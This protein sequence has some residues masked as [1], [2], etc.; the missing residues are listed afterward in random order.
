MPTRSTT[1]FLGPFLLTFGLAHTAWGQT[2]AFTYQ[3]RLTDNGAAVNGL[4][5]FRAT[6]YGEATGSGSAMAQ[7]VPLVGTNVE[8]GLFTLSIELGASVWLDCSNRWLEIEVRTNGAAAWQTLAPRTRVTPTPYAI[9]AYTACSVADNAITSQ[10]IAAGQA[11]KS[12]NGLTDL[13]TLSP[14]ANITFAT[15]GNNIEISS[16]GGGGPGWSLTGNS[17][18]TPG[19][20]FVGTTDNQALEIKVNN[21]RALRIDPTGGV[22]SLSGGYSQNYASG[23]GGV[24][25]GGGTSGSINEAVGM[26]AFVGAGHGSKAGPFSGVVGGAYNVSF[27][28]FSFIGSGQANTNQSPASVIVGGSNNVIQA[29]SDA[30]FIGGGDQNN[31]GPYSERAAIGGGFVNRIHWCPTREW[32]SREPRIS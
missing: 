21:T 14:G 26:Y 4:Y 23:P 17:G 18:T 1:H 8:N 31:I 24:V 9:S 5:D 6:L 12:L 28:P 20:N 2:T 10:M 3:G 13:V 27:S 11:V 19:V 32:I 15:N 29:G 22:P 16:T 7:T 30:S 25:A